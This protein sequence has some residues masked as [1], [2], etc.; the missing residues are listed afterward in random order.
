M[1]TQNLTG[2]TKKG[3]V[4]GIFMG[5]VMA[6]LG[7]LLIAYHLATAVITTVLMGWTLA[8]VGIAQF[9]FALQSQTPGKWLM[10][11]LEGALCSVCGVSLALFPI[12]GAA[13]LTA[14]L[15]TLL[16]VQAVLLTTSA[17]QQETLD[18]CIWFLAAADANWLFGLLIL[19]RWP[20]SSVWAIGT[21]VGI[22][23]L[24]GG[25]C[26]IVLATKMGS[27]GNRVNHCIQHSAQT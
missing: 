16:L 19:A 3:S 9:V 20:S 14:V 15:G 18:G 4:W 24:L 13:A 26:R 1:R 27:G 11:V 22:S 25:I 7:A 6:A 2:E 5:F 23:V 12:K 10:K 17:F 21:L 8:V